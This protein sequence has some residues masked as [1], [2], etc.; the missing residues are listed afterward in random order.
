MN[1]TIC[2]AYKLKENFLV[3]D[4]AMHEFF[5]ISS[6]AAPDTIIFNKDRIIVK[7]EYKDCNK[8]EKK[9]FWMLATKTKPSLK[10]F[11]KEF[12]TLTSKE[13]LTNIQLEDEHHWINDHLN[14]QVRFY[15]KC[16]KFFSR[17]VL[18]EKT[19]I[20]P[21]PLSIF[22]PGQ[23]YVVMGRPVRTNSI[24]QKLKRMMKLVQNL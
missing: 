11:E 22:G 14:Q 9:Q 15:L 13:F 3:S 17:Q 4:N 2:T 24:L 20:I 5:R 19:I 21:P 7:V 18:T 1:E 8:K 6:R 12:K 23:G 10:I 16:S